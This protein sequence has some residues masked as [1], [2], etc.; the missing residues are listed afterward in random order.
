MYTKIQLNASV[1]IILLFI[2]STVSIEKPESKYVPEEEPIEIVEEIP[3]PEIKDYDDFA[4]HLAFKES[5]NRYD[6]VNSF[7]YLGRYQ[8]SPNVLWRLGYKV[9]AEEF[10]DDPQMQDEA[11]RTLLTHNKDILEETIDKYEGT[12]INGIEITESGILAAA[13]LI[14]PTRTK[15]FL[16]YKRNAKDGYGTYLTDYLYE[17]KGYKLDLE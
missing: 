1:W 10:L 3:V 12:T 15:L 7:G 4:N 17:F 13:H 16:K 9:R 8:F 5:S 2:Y 11:F 6:A 14:G